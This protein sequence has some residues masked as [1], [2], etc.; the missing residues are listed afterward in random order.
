MEFRLNIGLPLRHDRESVS[1][2][3]RDETFT[4]G[5]LMVPKQIGLLKTLPGQQDCPL[6]LTQYNPIG[7]AGSLYHGFDVLSMNTAARFVVRGSGEGEEGT[8][9]SRLQR[10]LDWFN[11]SVVYEPLPIATAPMT[12]MDES[13]LP[14]L[15]KSAPAV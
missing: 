11:R 12:K 7:K 8:V 13:V 9:E 15:P 4:I 2:L 1:P 14:L 10:A 6:P 3:L 5:D